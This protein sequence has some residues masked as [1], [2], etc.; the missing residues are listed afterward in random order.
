MPTP[1]L[2]ITGTV[3]RV[4]NGACQSN[5]E[6]RSRAVAVHGGQQN[7]ARAERHH[8]LRIG[9]RL[10]AG[11]LAPAMGEDLEA[12]LVAVATDA[13]GVDGHHDAL[14]AE[15]LRSPRAPNRGP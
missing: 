1:P 12:R 9:D 2:A 13:L 10:D 14:R 8:L 6:A 15:F 7:F 4:G 5:I 3:H 11:R